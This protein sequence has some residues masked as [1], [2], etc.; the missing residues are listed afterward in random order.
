MT[1]RTEGH[2]RGGIFDALIAQA[3]LKIKSS[4]DKLS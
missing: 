2:H 4:Q 3:A 1:D